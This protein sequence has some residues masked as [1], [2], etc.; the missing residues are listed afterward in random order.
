M[1]T[2]ED[3]RDIAKMIT[4]FK[5]ALTAGGERR[6]SEMIDAKVPLYFR[7]PNVSKVP[8]ANS[9]VYRR[10][11]TTGKLEPFTLA[12]MMPFTISNPGAS[13]DDTIFFTTVAIT[14]DEMEVVLL[15]SSTPSVTFNIVHHP[16][17][18][19]A[20]NNVFTSDQVVT[21]ETTGDNLTVFV[22]GTI[23]ADSFV[24]LE[25]QAQSGTVDEFHVT[26]HWIE[27]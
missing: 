9:Q 19:N 5:G 10:N 27:D 14:L 4:E 6:V 21:N 22:D 1:L 23:P 20:G 26:L 15:G 16:D 11:S 2:A 18:S 13:Q 12:G 7:S 3:K 25:T 24:W 17:R 8:P